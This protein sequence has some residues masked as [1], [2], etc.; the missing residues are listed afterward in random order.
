M[1]GGGGGGAV[2]GQEAIVKSERE[3]LVEIERRMNVYDNLFGDVE[4]DLIAESTGILNQKLIDPLNAEIDRLGTLAADADVSVQKLR[5][6]RD[7]IEVSDSGGI[8]GSGAGRV[9]AAVATGGSSELY[10]AA[11]MPGFE[12]PTSGT[13][14][15]GGSSPNIK[16]L[17]DGYVEEQMPTKGNWALGQ[18][19]RQA[20]NDQISEILN[21]KRK[22]KDVLAKRSEAITTQQNN[23]KSEQTEQG[24]ARASGAVDTAFNAAE[25]TVDVRNEGLGIAD[26]AGRSA[27]ETNKELALM[28]AAAEAGA[29]NKARSDITAL[30]KAKEGA[31]VGGDLIDRAAET[32]LR[33]LSDLYTGRSVRSYQQ[34]DEYG[35]QKDAA[36]LAAIR[37]VGKMGGTVAGY[38]LADKGGTSDYEGDS[39]GNG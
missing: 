17:G 15:K 32:Q 27:E 20:L 6:K 7:K 30:A 13:Q 14:T 12:A 3:Q 33:G 2:E 18:K 37:G 34:A 38:G 36:T 9:V 22:Q 29:R 5:N 39:G 4:R 19:R 23:S 31:I 11:N 25:R 1:T 8:F 24:R 35:R 28:K 10:R 26:Q 16:D 21:A